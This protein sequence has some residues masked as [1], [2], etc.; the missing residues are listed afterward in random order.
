MEVGVDCVKTVAREHKQL[1]ILFGNIMMK[2]RTETELIAECHGGTEVILVSALGFY[3]RFGSLE[4]L[5]NLEQKAEMVPSMLKCFRES[6]RLNR[7]ISENR[8]KR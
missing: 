8:E 1:T 3:S 6:H 2:T 4:S 5:L 7:S